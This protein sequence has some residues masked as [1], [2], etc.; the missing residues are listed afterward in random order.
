VGVGW[1]EACDNLLLFIAGHYTNPRQHRDQHKGKAI[2][3]G[4]CQ[5]DKHK[6]G[7]T[8][9]HGSP[10]TQPSI[11]SFTQRPAVAGV[12]VPWEMGRGEGGR[13]GGYK[14]DT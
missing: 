13:K 3:V 9:E 11:G 6:K 1:V 14:T 10:S 2:E 12:T 5:N 4:K 7:R 8:T